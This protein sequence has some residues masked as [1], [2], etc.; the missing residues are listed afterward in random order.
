[1]VPATKQVKGQAVAAL[2]RRGKAKPMWGAENENGADACEGV[3]GAAAAS[4]G[5]VVCAGVRPHAPA[6]GASA[7]GIGVVRCRPATLRSCPHAPTLLFRS[8]SLSLA[9]RRGKTTKCLN[10]A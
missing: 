3:Y 10:Y 2:R 6:P 7:G 8:L 4:S 1:M 9:T 5:G